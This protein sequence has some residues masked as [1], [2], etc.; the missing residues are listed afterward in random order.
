MVTPINRVDINWQT[1][2]I[3]VPGL[4][5]WAAWRI[6]RLRRAVIF[7]MPIVFSIIIFSRW[8]ISFSEDIDSELS[9]YLLSL[10]SLGIFIIGANVIIH[11][12]RKWSRI[13]NEKMENYVKQS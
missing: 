10:V 11:Y 13:W 1:L 7:F 2:F 6:E 8:M 5:V 4:N 3:F 9:Q 12:F